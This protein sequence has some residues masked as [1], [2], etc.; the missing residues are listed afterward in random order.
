MASVAFH[1]CVAVSLVL[2]IAPL[3]TQQGTNKVINFHLILF[4]TFIIKL[5]T[6]E[7]DKCLHDH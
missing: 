5:R 2:T 4:K 3:V 1:L 7:I 6:G